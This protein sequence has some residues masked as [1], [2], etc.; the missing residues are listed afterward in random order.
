M[1][2]VKHFNSAIP[3]GLSQVAGVRD[4]ITTDELAQ[5]LSKAVQTIRKTHCECGAVYGIK[6]V[7][8]GN[9][10]LWP[11]AKVAELL[12]GGAV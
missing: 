1:M 6:P 10:L 11:V 3:A 12:E 2:M 8:V 4:F 7:K 5:C 9:R